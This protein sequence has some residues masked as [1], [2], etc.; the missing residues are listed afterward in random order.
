[1]GTIANKLE[2]LN[3]TK[4][5]FKNKLNSIGAEIDNSTKFR[6][7]INILDDIYDKANVASEYEL[8]GDT[9]QTTY[10]GIQ[11][12]DIDGTVESGT[13]VKYNNGLKL[14]G[15]LVNEMVKFD[16]PEELSPSTDYTIKLDIVKNTLQ[17]D[18][19]LRVTLYDSTLG[20]EVSVTEF[21]AS[22]S[23]TISLWRDS[24]DKISFSISAPEEEGAEMIIDNIIL[25]KGTPSSITYEPYVGGKASPNPDY[26]QNI[27]VVTGRQEV[28]INGKNLLK[29]SNDTNTRRNQFTYITETPELVVCN[30]NESGSNFY[31]KYEI[32]IEQGQK[33]TLSVEDTSAKTF[34]GYSDDL[35]GTAVSGL[36]NQNVS[37]SVPFKFTASYTGN[38]VIGFYGNYN[39]NPLT[40]TKP[41]I[42]KGSTATTYEAFKG[43]SYEINLGK[44]L[45]DISTAD[46]VSK[47][48]LNNEIYTTDTLIQGD[49]NAV[50][51]Y[52]ANN[53]YTVYPNETYYL[54]ADIKL[55]SGTCSGINVFRFNTNGFTNTM[56]ISP[57]FTEDYVRVLC[58]ATNTSTAPIQAGRILF[59]PN[60]SGLSNAVFE[61]KNVMI[62]KSNDT[63]Y[64]P[65]KPQ[66]ELCKIGTY[67]DRIYKDNGT[68][69]LHKEI[70]KVV[71]DGSESWSK[72]SSRPFYTLLINDVLRLQ[73]AVN[74]ATLFC[75]YLSPSTPATIWGNN[76]N[77]ITNLDD[78]NAI[79]IRIQDDPY[80]ITTFKEWL[81]DVKPVVYYALETP[82][83][84]EITDSEL[85]SQLE[86]VKDYLFDYYLDEQFLLGYSD[87]EIIIK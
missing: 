11:L 76:I 20:S 53:N 38:L 49:R 68:W 70:G 24:C 79:R 43:Q 40:L 58:S 17:T 19:T 74:N 83:T 82:T 16:L 62:S 27:E 35:W 34:Y 33:Y 67:Q 41:M 50:F 45:F 57:S 55:V 13:L 10:S 32:Y 37:K 12:F 64:A 77:G 52:Q 36:S 4:E 75:N 78:G 26:P 8:E 3:D 81:N 6:D 7:Y 66:I 31:A 9:K 46:Y 15:N 84:E 73:S 60:N 48:T 61:I 69:Y 80:T 2:Y 86:A 22:G 65:Y 1:M 47:C 87:P 51:G 56:I 39:Y 72:G 28:S 42:E 85:I 23:Q 63:T 71:L 54:S 29:F 21:T 44:N 30:K 5:I 14:T 59:Q 18:P 25:V